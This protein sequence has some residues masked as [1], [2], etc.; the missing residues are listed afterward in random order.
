[1]R[2]RKRSR[3][4]LAC[5]R[6]AGL[7]TL[8][9]AGSALAQPAD[10]DWVDWERLATGEVDFK[11]I[12]ESRGTVTIDIAI[13]IHADWQSI[14]NVLVSCDISPDFVPHVVACERVATINDG[15][16]EL[17]NQTVKPAFFL[18]KFDHVFRLDYFPPE[19]I[20]VSH[21]NGPID[22]MEGSWRLIER[23]EGVVALVHS[24]TLKPGFPV[25]RMFVRR[26]L[27]RDMPTIL[28]AIRSRAEA[29]ADSP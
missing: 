11:T 15:R 29:A 13:A 24:M 28:T 9:T 16:A 14:W 8:I 20:E 17:F 23:P 10:L 25:P 6:V 4:R 5:A 22:R 26:T 18:P 7:I 19:R 27:E 3:S 12:K 1:M 2:I 21:V